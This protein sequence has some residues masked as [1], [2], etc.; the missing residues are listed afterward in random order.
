MKPAVMRTLLSLAVATA[1]AGCSL[2]P[3]YE[4]PQAPVDAAYPS[5][6]AYG[7]PGQAAAGAP[8]A[9]DVGWRDFFGDPLLQELLALSLANNRDLRVAAL[10]VEAARAQY[11]IQRADLAPSVGVGGTGSVQRTPADLNPSGQA[12]VSRSYQVGASLSTWELDLFGRIRSLSEQALQLYLAQDETRLA[13]QLTLVAETANAYLTL[14]ADQEL[15]ALTRQTLAAQQESYKLTRQSYDLGVATE[16][17]LSQAEISLRT[18][19][20]NLSQYTRMAAQDRNALVLLVGQP[21]PAGIGAQLDQAV[22]LPDGVVLADL[23]AGLPS[24][25][26][27]RRPD[28]RAAEHQLQ[29]ANASIGAA[30][31]AFFP[32]IS[33]TGSAGTAS[34][35]LGGLFD[36]GSGAWSFAPQISVPIFAGGALRASLD[37]AKIQKDIGIARYEQAIQSG[38]RE[39][40]DA[41]AGRGTLQEQ[42]RSQ[43]LLVQANQRAYDLSQQRYQ[44][45]IDNYLSVLDSQRSLYTAQQTLVE[46]RLARL[47]NLIQLY[48][49]LGGGWS[50][51]TVAAAQAG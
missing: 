9:A 31:A 40:S 13:T 18:A 48:K 44:Q 29:A 46:T 24:D 7:A 42:I 51:R 34:A 41:L 1:L 19:E 49:A 21:L 20:R 16:L 2:A 26:L 10:N 17:D 14:R 50:E 39:V 23:P 25:L 22:A 11:R 47:S 33:L 38:F 30:R 35:S 32:R 36:A 5:G 8:A 27:A 4:R 37:L 45:G 3:T 28:I 12:G 15:L 6:P 43:E